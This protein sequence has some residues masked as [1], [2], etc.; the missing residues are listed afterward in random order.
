MIF[1]EKEQDG[2]M[3]LETKK[4]KKKSGSRRKKKI[5]LCKNNGGNCS[6]SLRGDD[7]AGHESNDNKKDNYVSFLN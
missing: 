7:N 1:T 3:D 5:T 2:V 6:R 4:R